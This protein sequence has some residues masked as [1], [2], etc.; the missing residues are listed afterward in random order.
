MPAQSTYR[1]KMER[2]RQDRE[3]CDARSL[4]QDV[5][6]SGQQQDRLCIQPELPASGPVDG[7]PDPYQQQ[8]AH[9]DLLNMNVCADAVY[10]GSLSCCFAAP[11]TFTP[12]AAD[13][14]PLDWPPDAGE[15]LHWLYITHRLRK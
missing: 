5:I 7:Q 6:C 9:M 10:K 13:Q 8:A 1:R 3:A 11:V 15:T 2:G 14:M 12:G 4:Q